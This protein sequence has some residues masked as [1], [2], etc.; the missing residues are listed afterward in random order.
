NT[1]RIWD[2]HGHPVAKPLTGHTGVTAVAVGR[3][4]TR[5]VIVSAGRDNT[6]RIWDEHGHPVG[7]PTP[8]LETPSAVALGAHCIVVATGRALV[9]F[10][11]TS[12]EIT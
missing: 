11:E 6:V 8:L 7:I 10:T 12:W 2:E 5:D 1:V 3:L 9:S 4:G